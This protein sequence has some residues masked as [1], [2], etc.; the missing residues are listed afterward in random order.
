MVVTGKPKFREDTGWNTETW[1][2]GWRSSVG[3]AKKQ[4]RSRERQRELRFCGNRGTPHSRRP[5][6]SA[7]PD[8]DARSLHKGGKTDVPRGSTTRAH[9]P[10]SPERPGWGWIASRDG[11]R[12]C[13][14]PEGPRA[15]A[16]D[17]LCHW[18]HAG[19]SDFPLFSLRSLNLARVPEE[20]RQAAREQASPWSTSRYLVR[21]RAARG[22]A[23]APGKPPGKRVGPCPQGALTGAGSRE[24]ATASGIFPPQGLNTRLLHCQT[25]PPGKLLK[26]HA[27]PKVKSSCPRDSQ[28]S[29]PTPQFKSINFLVLS[30]LYEQFRSSSFSYGA[31]SLGD[32]HHAAS[33]V[34]ESSHKLW[35]RQ[36]E[37]QAAN[38]H[39]LETR[40]AAPQWLASANVLLQAKQSMSALYPANSA[41]ER[42]HQGWTHSG[43]HASG[44]QPVSRDLT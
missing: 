43:K 26:G 5:E 28:E 13:P 15:C 42:A 33:G 12:W 21:R 4:P 34:L 18:A 32:H 8:E 29:S 7:R 31:D 22:G 20:N 39:P 24:K 3:P 23:R 44:C 17:R 27:A 25:E 1:R 36:P 9:R 38:Q 10:R 11:S 2:R 6:S 40:S 35:K 37:K 41:S 16:L 30:P 14:D 19:A